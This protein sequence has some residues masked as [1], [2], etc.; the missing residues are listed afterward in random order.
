MERKLVEVG[1]KRRQVGSIDAFDE[2][3][4]LGTDFDLIL[5]AARFEQLRHPSIQPGEMEAD[6]RLILC[7]YCKAKLVDVHPSL[8]LRHSV[9]EA[10]HSAKSSRW[11]ALEA[12]MPPE[13][14][15]GQFSPV[16]RPMSSK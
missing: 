5:V 8:W 6:F 9:R 13:L 15:N 11:G 2:E 16:N 7:L 3:R 4:F 1:W 12:V 14:D 10:V